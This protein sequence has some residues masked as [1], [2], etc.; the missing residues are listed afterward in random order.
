[1]EGESIAGLGNVWSTGLVTNKSGHYVRFANKENTRGKNQRLC[2]KK[3]P[4]ISSNYITC[5]VKMPLPAQKYITVLEKPDA[6]FHV[7]P[8]VAVFIGIKSQ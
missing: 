6:Y 4:N 7:S 1:M 5:K 3:Q 2:I 8:A